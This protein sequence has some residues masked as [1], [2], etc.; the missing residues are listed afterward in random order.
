MRALAIVQETRYK[1]SRSDELCRE[2]RQRP[3]PACLVRL[4]DTGSLERKMTNP[5]TH[6][7]QRTVVRSNTGTPS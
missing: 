4:A 3:I 1:I 5:T 7:G 6:V 2:T